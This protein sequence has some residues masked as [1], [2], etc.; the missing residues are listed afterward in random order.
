[1]L[2][3]INP[4]M[5]IMRNGLDPVPE[6]GEVRAQ[7]PVVELPF[8]EGITVWL[9][10]GYE[11]VRK[12]LGDSTNFSNA[13]SNLEAIGLESMFESLDP[14]GLGFRD[15]P[16]HTRLRRLLAPEFTHRRLQRLTPMIDKL[17]VE[18]LDRLEAHGSPADLVAQFAISLPLSVVFDLLGI[19]EADRG[20]LTADN[21]R[22]DLATDFTSG[23]SS[24]TSTLSYLEELV[25]RERQN[26]GD[27]MLGMLI[28]EHGDEVSDWELAGLADGMITG[29]HDT[30][31]GMLAL[32]TVYLLTHPELAQMMRAGENVDEI[33]EELLRYISVVQVAFPRF[34]KVDMELGGKQI[35]AGDGVLC[36][37]SA[38]NRDPLQGTDMDKVNTSRAIA[39]HLAF[40]YGAHHCVGAPLARM[41]LTAALPALLRRFPDLRLDIDPGQIAYRPMSIVYGAAQIPIAWG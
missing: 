9:V 28:R 4:L 17:V 6:L 41:E 26:P 2:G 15:P 1:M 37:L 31:A 20:P 21:D 14:G 16:D 8:M 24:V 23:L 7:A 12:V 27:G 39:T 32:G 34:A 35:H 29:G 10:T 3:A 30:T 38:A 13:F 36:S 11:E 33:V 40:G 5:P 18:H 22:F 25:K 19:A